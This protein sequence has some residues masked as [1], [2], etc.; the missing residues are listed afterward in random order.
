MRAALQLRR[1]IEM[2]VQAAPLSEAEALSV[3]ALY[4]PWASGKAYKAGHILKHGANDNGD[5]NLYSVLQDHTSQS[6]WM[7][8]STPSLYKR[9]GFTGDGIP[10]WVQPL[11]ASDAYAKGDVVSHSG[12]AWTSDADA[13]VWEPGV[14]GWSVTA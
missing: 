7:P 13:N 10:L 3:A 9:I 14:H 5:V 8:D 6:G 2:F 11:G 4:E 1:A 12:K